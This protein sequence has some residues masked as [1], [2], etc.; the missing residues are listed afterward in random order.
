VAHMNEEIKE[1]PEVVLVS[2]GRVLPLLPLRDLVMFPHMVVPLLVGRKKS[3]EAVEHAVEGDRLILLATQKSAEIEEPNEDDIYRIGTIGEV[4]QILRQVDGSLKIL[5]E[6]KARARIKQFLPSENFYLVEAEELGGSVERSVEIEALMRSI[7]DQFAQYIELSQRIPQEVLLSIRSIED[8]GRLADMVAAHLAAKVED[9]QRI[10]EAIDP[11]ERLERL[12]QLLAAEIE[13]AQ[14]ERKIQGEV[15]KQME[16]TQK[17]YYLQE[18]LKAIQKELGRQDEL[19]AEIE[20]LKQKIEAA[21]MPKEVK[22]KALHEVGRLSKMMP[23]SPEA[24]VVRN[25]LDWLIN[26]PWS[27]K[28]R[29]NLNIKRARAILDEDHYDL[30]KVKE[31]ILEFL[32]VRKL[33]KKMRGPILCFVGPPGVGKTSLGKSI[34]RALGREFVRMSLGGVRDEAEVRGHRRTYIGA[35]PGRIIQG[36]RR[37]GTKNP[38]FLLDEVDKIGV[39]FRGDPAAALLEVLDPEQNH[40][41]NDHYLE[42]DFDLSDVLF[43][44][45]ANVTDTIPPALLDR[46]EIIHL[47]GYTEEEKVK[48]AQQF[49]IPKQLKAHGLKEK[50]LKISE[51]ALRTIV[52]HYTREAGV[53]NLERNIESICRKVARAI[54][55]EK[56]KE[57]TIVTQRNIHKF[58]GPRKFRTT[59]AEEGNE[60]GVAFGLAWTEFGGEVLATEA[61]VLK[62]KG[63]LMLTGKL[64]EV[65]QESAHAALS[66]V[67]SRARDLGIPEDFYEKVDIHVHVPEGAIPKDGPSAGITIATAI[68]SALTKKPVR[69]D[70]AMTGEITLR[71]KILPVGG[72]KAKILAAHRAG[73]KTVLLPSENKADL[74][75]IPKQIRKEMEFIFVD[76]V[77]K[78]LEIALQDKQRE[79]EKQK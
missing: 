39:D 13:I 3:I 76:N 41:F 69:K 42:V 58:L 37:A 5:V 35:L 17:E 71:G 43:I 60:V 23:T 54:A 28:T 68:A 15:R 16:K 53:R 62:G 45:T 14:L 19:Y 32:A 61:T 7:V 38:V 33:V 57:P 30:E 12:N 77:D 48:I 49:L 47:P 59:K 1:V 72:I 67:R 56:K 27:K 8:P 2:E 79:G 66:Y 50:Q 73:I 65:M 55:E 21:G 25:Y 20:E 34:A 29:D 4:L 18:Q 6:G 52:R 78:V 24:T 46:M 10:L 26:L 11:R 9:K 63:N 64:G 36:I 40:A 44:T 51:E 31:R 75:E 74:E 70:V 22:E